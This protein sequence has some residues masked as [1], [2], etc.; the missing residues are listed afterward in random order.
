MLIRH[1]EIDCYLPSGTRCVD[2]RIEAGH[3]VAL[4]PQLTPEPH[5]P[6]LEAHGHTLLPGLH[7]H[8]LH[9]AA[10]AVALDSLSCGPPDVMTAEALADALQTHAH[11]ANEKA[12][13]GDAGAWIRGIGYHESVAGNIDRAWLDRIVP[14]RPVRIQHRSGRLWICNS[15][16]LERL[17]IAD[18]TDGRLLD[19]DLRL[20][21]SQPRHFP[22]LHHASRLLAQ[23]GVTGVTDTT[24]HND[25]A[26]FQHFATARAANTLWQDVLLMGDAS[27]NKT[28][29]M[30]EIGLWRGATKFHLH[31]YALPDFDALVTMMQDSHAADRP[32]AIHCVTVAELVFA[33]GALEMAGAHP[34]DRIEHA[35][36]V[37]PDILPLLT[38][39]RVTVVTQPNFI[40]ERGDVYQSEVE[41]TDQPWLYRLRGLQEAG[42]ALAGSTDA[43]FG[44]A[45]P[46]LAMQAA[47][48]RRSRHGIVLGADEALSPE[49]AL[50]LFLS[51]LSAPGATARRLKEG[52]RAD[53]C[54]LDRNWQQARAALG[55]VRI[56]VCFKQGQR[57]AISDKK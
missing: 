45:N 13:E 50:R 44:Q 16:A 46:W 29:D 23:H 21:E 2:I 51:P 4:A 15:L 53:L 55:S 1:A 28:Q 49:A 56:E 35:A 38:A 5:E 30:P 11:G 31:E 40:F 22:S 25:L 32:V 57:M 27:L 12:E 34:G 24:P 6:V 19:A 3:I 42:I 43:P 7:D 41:A 14:Q 17:G 36:L 26:Q 52:V 9:L 37:P 10:L 33:L 39:R 54:L 48:E 47:V 8:H 18:V 20:R